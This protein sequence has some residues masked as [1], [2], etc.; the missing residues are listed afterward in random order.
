MLRKATE[1]DLE[2]VYTLICDMEQRQLPLERFSAIFQAQLQDEHY[3]CLLCQQ[4]AKVIGV[5]NL[6]FEEQLHHA[7]RIAEILELAVDGAYRRQGVGKELLAAACQL[8]KE[9][10][11]SQIEVA[12]NQL[13]SDTHRFYLREGLHNFHFRFSKSLRGDDAPENAIG[14]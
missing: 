2:R 7:E 3:F 4:D 12:C 9:Q 5:L 13:R 14:K 1:K 6:R 10:G 8:A 11:C